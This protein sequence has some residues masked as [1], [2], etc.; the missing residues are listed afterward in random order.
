MSKSVV[1]G[2]PQWL[3]GKEPICQSKRPGFDPWVGKIPW[4][5]KWQHT[6]VFLP[7]KS[8]GQR[9]LAGYSQV[10]V[11]QLCLTL[12]DPMDC[13][14]P[15]SSVHG[16]LQLKILECVAISFSRASS[17]PRDWTRVFCMGGWVLYHWHQRGATILV[18][19][20][21]Y[22]CPRTDSKSNLLFKEMVGE[23]L[24]RAT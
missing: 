20:R 22:S 10:K 1:A 23:N 14:P 13:S 18:L 17:W 4:R 11:T 16:I 19:H 3:S 8:Y 7:G 24:F 2:L 15:G 21:A 12:C 5:R 9:S 6:P